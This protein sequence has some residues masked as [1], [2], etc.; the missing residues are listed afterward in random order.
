MYQAAGLAWLKRQAT[1]AEQ[2]IA[3][4]PDSLAGYSHAEPNRCL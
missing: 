2:L 4:R 1:I 3:V